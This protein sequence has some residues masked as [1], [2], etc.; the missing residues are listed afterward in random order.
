[1]FLFH[2]AVQVDLSILIWHKRDL[3]QNL[4]EQMH[5]RPWKRQLLDLHCLTD[6]G[7]VWAREPHQVWCVRAQQTQALVA[8]TVYLQMLQCVADPS[9]QMIPVP[10][11]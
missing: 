6:L 11:M 10:S 4:R 9:E 2:D 1:M 8:D 3:P 5:I 7:E